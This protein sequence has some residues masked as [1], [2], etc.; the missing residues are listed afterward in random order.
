M[1][2]LGP[3]PDE[4]TAQMAP[5]PADYTVPLV[6]DGKRIYWRGKVTVEEPGSV[7]Q[8]DVEVGYRKIHGKTAA[9]DVL[10]LVWHIQE[11]A[12]LGWRHGIAPARVD[13]HRNVKPTAPDPKAWRE[14]QDAA[15][16]IA[17][18]L[19]RQAEIDTEAARLTTLA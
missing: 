19:A 12:R 1:S 16:D 13:R 11:L 14:A 15:A 8:I 9:D 2:L 17:A 3:L 5:R 10:D 18:N 7:E 4:V 6:D